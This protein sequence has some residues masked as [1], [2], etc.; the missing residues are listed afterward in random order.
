MKNFHASLLSSA[1]LLAGDVL[2]AQA[3]SYEIPVRVNGKPIVS[4]EVRDAIREQE[5]LIR[6]Q[7][8]NSKVAES[9]VLEVRASALFTLME[10]Q[11][12]LSEFE[13]RG[14]PINRQYVEDY[15]D[16]FIRENFGGDRKKFLHELAKAGLTLPGFREQRE[17]M[18]VVSA[19]RTQRVK[20]LPPPTPAQVE[21]YY[22]KNAEKFRTHEYIKFS[23]ITIP[24]Y[25]VNDA[26]AT[27]ESQKK[28]AEDIRMKITSGSDFSQMAKTHSTDPYADA[29]GDRGLQERASINKE[30]AI[31]AF[32]LKT[33]AVSEVVDVDANYMILL[34]EAKQGG[35]LEPLEKV[36]PQ[37]EKA[38]AAE[39]GREAVNRWLS[40]LANKA[41][42]QPEGVKRDFL[43]W[44]GRQQSMEE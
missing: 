18:I 32:G 17:K 21:A 12:V 14:A 19:L 35:K 10:Q 16:N 28:L 26:G 42:I 43:A 39:M 4:S 1:L 11:L 13:Q 36:R 33:G 24:K 29:G 3:Q 31:A 40:G 2:H 41:I 23:T 44:V 15:I 9:R 25:P 8:G 5:Q 38:V 30:V 22:R 27:P 34:C 6:M 20:A 37:I 7:F